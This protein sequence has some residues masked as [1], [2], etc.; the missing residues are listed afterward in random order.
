VSTDR[1][2][3]G[4]THLDCPSVH[5]QRNIR[6]IKINGHIGSHGAYTAAWVWIHWL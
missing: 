2:L 4:V 5:P 1:N 3:T 6:C